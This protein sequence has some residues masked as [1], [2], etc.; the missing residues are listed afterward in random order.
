M[1]AQKKRGGGEGAGHNSE[2]NNDR[3]VNAVEQRLEGS[4]IKLL[5]YYPE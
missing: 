3:M 1:R 2:N 4:Y 5:K